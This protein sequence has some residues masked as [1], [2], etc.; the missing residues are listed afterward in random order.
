MSCSEFQLTDDEYVSDE[1]VYSYSQ[2]ANATLRKENG[3]SFYT[4]GIQFA[5]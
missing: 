2:G 5:T 4:S 3:E 1:N